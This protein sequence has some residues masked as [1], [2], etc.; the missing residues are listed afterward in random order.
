[1]GFDDVK[2]R[3]AETGYRV[4]A[5]AVAEAMLRRPGVRLLLDPRLVTP[6]GGAR[7]PAAAPQRRPGA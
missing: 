7:S 2:G 5:G 4:D 3:V 6:G 1:M